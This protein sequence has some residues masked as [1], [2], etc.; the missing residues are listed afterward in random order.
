MTQPTLFQKTLP[1]MTVLMGGVLFGFGLSISGM[2]SPEIVLGFL[3]GSD[4][5]LLLVMGGA[6]LITLSTYQLS[7]RL[8]RKPLLSENFVK[9]IANVDKPTLIG[10]AIFG[11]GWGICGVCP[12]P[13]LAAIG[14][15]NLDILWA[16]VG[17]FIGA[18]LRSFLTD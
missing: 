11:I 13:A 2:I 12:G 7:A 1:L 15:G 17:I 8:M 5:G 10:A 9:R 4:Y 18:F 14:A 3:R 16:L 6:I